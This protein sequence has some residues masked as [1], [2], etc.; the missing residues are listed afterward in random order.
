MKAKDVV[1]ENVTLAPVLSLVRIIALLV[2]ACMLSKVISMHA[3]T[4]GEIWD[5]AVHKHGV[6]VVV[7]FETIVGTPELV[8][9]ANDCK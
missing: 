3:A 2:G 8:L 9:V 6:A 4:A 1:P 5:H 7:V